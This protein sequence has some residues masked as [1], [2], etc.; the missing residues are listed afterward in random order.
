M[1]D[2]QAAQT[3]CFIIANAVAGIQ[4]S[5]VTFRPQT[6][7]FQSDWPCHPVWN[8]AFCSGKHADVTHSIVI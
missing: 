8:F 2:H 7:V 4:G 6:S 3:E 5:Y 1:S